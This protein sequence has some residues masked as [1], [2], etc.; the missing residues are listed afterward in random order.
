MTLREHATEIAARLNRP[1]DL[2][3]IERAK[4]LIV[5]TTS[6]LLRQ[7]IE[8]SG[9]DNH[10]RYTFLV[11]CKRTTISDLGIVSTS[12]GIGVPVYRSKHT[13]PIPLRYKTDS[14]FL[15]VGLNSTVDLKRIPFAY[16]TA[17]EVGRV[18]NLPGLQ[19]MPVY[20]YINGFIIISN[21][22]SY[23]ESDLEVIVEM[24]PENFL[25][26][27]DIGNRTDNNVSEDMY[28]YLIPMDLV[29]TIY[30]IVSDR[31][32]QTID[33]ATPI[34]NTEKDVT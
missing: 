32:R 8:K 15:F 9:V 25:K 34:I 23:V 1:S 33:A 14:P 16:S 5:S 2:Y 12:P 28:D 22:G 7:S 6:L 4:P 10:V 27:V 30:G 17:N 29:E 26:A 24:V 13:I 11:D 19:T 18:N 31:L 21:V 20:S 3:L